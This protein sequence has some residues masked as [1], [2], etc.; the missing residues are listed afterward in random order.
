[1]VVKNKKIRN[2]TTAEGPAA[3]LVP[4]G[5]GVRDQSLLWGS[6]LYSALPS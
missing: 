2:L 4:F 6:L 3:R 1:V 5:V